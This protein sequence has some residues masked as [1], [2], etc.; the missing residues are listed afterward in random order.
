MSANAEHAALCQW[1]AGLAGA[2]LLLARFYLLWLQ[3][4]R[5]DPDVHPSPTTN[6]TQQMHDPHCMHTLFESIKHRGH[7]GGYILLSPNVGTH[8]APLACNTDGVK[9]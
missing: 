8:A 1:L 6:L 3:G 2:L 4:C 9:H 5:L 7:V